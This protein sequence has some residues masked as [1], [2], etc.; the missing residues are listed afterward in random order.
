MFRRLPDIFVKRPLDGLKTCCDEKTVGDT[1]YTLVDDD[2]IDADELPEKCLNDCIYARTGF[3]EPKFCFARGDLPVACGRNPPTTTPGTTTPE[4]TT[5][6]DLQCMASLP[7]VANGSHNCLEDGFGWP[8]GTVECQVTC[9]AEDG[10]RLKD[11]AKDSMICGPNN[12]WISE[13]RYCG[14]SILQT[15]YF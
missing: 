14:E 11:P 5:P 7:N 8:E 6:E 3:S 4:T 10:Y 1:S 12:Q 9:D 15:T 13:A 2:N